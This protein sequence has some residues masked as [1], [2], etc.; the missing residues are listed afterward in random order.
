MHAGYGV[1]AILAVQFS[2]PFIKFDPMDKYR[3]AEMKHRNGSAKAISKDAA[4]E[5]HKHIDIRVP[6]WVSAIVALVISALFLLVQF[7][8]L[9]QRK[10]EKK[11]VFTEQQISTQLIVDETKQPKIQDSQSNGLLFFF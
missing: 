11:I 8:K 4:L 2:K 5:L 9:G 6:Y 1:G 10:S 3:M 7:G